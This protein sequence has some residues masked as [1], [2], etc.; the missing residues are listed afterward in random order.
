MTTPE[1]IVRAMVTHRFSAL[2]ASEIAAAA[3]M[4]ESTVR[5]WLPKLHAEGLVRGTAYVGEWTTTADARLKFAAEAPDDRQE[6]PA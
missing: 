6:V 4:A 5:R 1:R 2:S 3:G